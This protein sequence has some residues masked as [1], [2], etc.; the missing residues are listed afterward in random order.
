MEMETGE[1]WVRDREAI[2]EYCRSLDIQYFEQEHEG[3]W[4][5][6]DLWDNEDDEEE[7]E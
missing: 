4:K 2:R 7:E 1:Q 6:S 3:E 5:L